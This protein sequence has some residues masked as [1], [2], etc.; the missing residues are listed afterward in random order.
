ME[1]VEEDDVVDEKKR[2]RRRWQELE[3]HEDKLEEESGDVLR[4]L[5]KE[6]EEVVGKEV[7][8]PYSA[9]LTLWGRL[10]TNSFSLRSDRM[11]TVDCLHHLLYRTQFFT[12]QGSRD[13][14]MS[15]EPFGTALYLIPSLLDHSCLPS[16]TT[17]FIGRELRVMALQSVERIG[18]AT[19]SYTSP[20]EDTQTRRRQQK[21]VV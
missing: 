20:M 2:L 3:G 7:A 12:K 18:V 15:P 21:Q 9:F 6:M 5:H 4:F 19:I 14:P 1:E 17:V 13:R 8:P 16:C 11:T 10:Q